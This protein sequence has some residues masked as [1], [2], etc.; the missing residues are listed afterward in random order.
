[1]L[2]LAIGN[3]L[4]AKS[5]PIVSNRP[6]FT[7]GTYTLKPNTVVLELGYQ[8]AFN[9]NGV[10]RST[11]TLPMLDLRLGLTS[12]F[13]MDILWSGKKSYQVDGKVSTSAFSDVALGSKYRLVQKQS[14][15]LSFLGILSF[16]TGS[17][18]ATSEH[19]DPTV[20]LS[21]DRVLSKNISAFGIFQGTSYVSSDKRVYD[22]Q[23]AV[24]FAFSHKKGWGSFIEYYSTVPLRSNG[25]IQHAIDAGVTYLITNDFQWDINGAVGLNEKSENYIGSGIA[26]RF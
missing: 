13:E 8:R 22:F 12:K 7:T 3:P 11:E 24:G 25:D 6:S 23:P 26:Y 2:L 5:S 20:G 18:T 4:L 14:Y 16:P 21:W 15:N 9:D 10:N 17:A 19:I 1:M